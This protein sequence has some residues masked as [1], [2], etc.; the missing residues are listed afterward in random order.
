[1]DRFQLYLHGLTAAL[2]RAMDRFQVYLQGAGGACLFEGHHRRSG[3]E[4][5]EADGE[6]WQ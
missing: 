5:V 2:R 4:A 1:M 6:E 3:A